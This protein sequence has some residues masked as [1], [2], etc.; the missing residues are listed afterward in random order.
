MR[1]CIRCHQSNI[2]DNRRV[3]T[4]CLTDWSNMRITAANQLEKKF[5]KLTPDNHED[6]KKEMRRLEKIWRKAPDQFEQEL[7]KIGI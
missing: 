1:T 4:S 3:C 2:F 5:G 7:I 6:F